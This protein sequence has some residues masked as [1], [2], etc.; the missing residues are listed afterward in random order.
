[1]QSSSRFRSSPA[2]FPPITAATRRA[3]ATTDIR[4]TE[5]RYADAPVG[6]LIAESAPLAQQPAYR[7]R[8]L[9]MRFHLLDGSRFFGSQKA[10]A[11]VER[12]G[13]L[14]SRP[15]AANEA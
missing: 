4:T 11:A 7:F 9:D 6:L 14:P 3:S 12:I 8:A 1:M 13:H 10:V 15:V 5:I 2:D